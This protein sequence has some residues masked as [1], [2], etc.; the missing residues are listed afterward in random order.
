MYSH[1]VSHTLL[2]GVYFSLVDLGQEG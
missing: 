2:Q 1:T